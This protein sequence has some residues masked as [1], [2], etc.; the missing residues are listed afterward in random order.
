M[1][2]TKAANNQ[3]KQ[4]KLGPHVGKWSDDSDVDP[5]TQFYSRKVVITES[6]KQEKDSKSRKREKERETTKVS[7]N[8]VEEKVENGEQSE[9][10]KQVQ[11]MQT[12][13]QLSI[14]ERTQ[15][16]YRAQFSSR[17]TLMPDDQPS[18]NENSNNIVESQRVMSSFLFTENKRKE[19]KYMQQDEKPN[20]EEEDI[21]NKAN[22]FGLKVTS[23]N[24]SY[25]KKQSVSYITSI[26]TRRN[27]DI[28]VPGGNFLKGNMYFKCSM[29]ELK[30]QEKM[31]AEQKLQ[32]EELGNELNEEYD[33][34]MDEAGDDAFERMKNQT[35][36]YFLE[37]NPTIKCR[38]CLE[39]GHIAKDCTNKTKRPNCIL[40]GKDTHDSFSC[41]EKTCFKCNKIGHLASQCTEKNI[42]KC[43]KCGII[44]HKE[45][46]CLKI[47]KGDYSESQ[48]QL[49]RCIQCGKKG[50]IKCLKERKSW[51]IAIDT[52]VKNN[53]NEFIEKQQKFQ[54]DT[55]NERDRS[56]RFS[57]DYADELN[58]EQMWL[59]EST[60][61]VVPEQLKKN[62]R[63]APKEQPYGIPR[64]HDPKDVYCCYCADKH[65]E[66]DC[67]RRMYSQGN[68]RYQQYEKIRSRLNHQAIEERDLGYGG[69]RYG[70]NYDNSN[71][72]NRNGNGNSSNN[73]HMR[74][75]TDPRRNNAN[76][77]QTY[78]IDSEDSYS[79]QQSKTKSHKNKKHR[80][81]EDSSESQEDKKYRKFN[82]KPQQ[83]DSYD[84][85]SSD[86]SEKVLTSFS[87]L[88]QKKKSRQQSKDIEQYEDYDEEY[89]NEYIDLDE[90]DDN[91]S[92]NK[93]NKKGGNK[94]YN[95]NT[96]GN[97]YSRKN[98]SYDSNYQSYHRDSYNNNYQGNQQRSRSRNYQGGERY[99]SYK[100][101]KYGR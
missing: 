14:A 45:A 50:H 77:I 34:N 61:I 11:I 101:G 42:I 22:K 51:K 83:V 53:L 29:E 97:N 69:S 20:N 43:N 6:T 67:P 58:E 25:S 32:N 30:E 74:L 33:V 89:E 73:Y 99:N 82:K 13:T 63:D 88:L 87:E 28:L 64:G 81:Y 1:S 17:N 76:Q 92:K 3:S 96:N 95:S 36:R 68:S 19:V 21:Q 62:G 10:T 86:D 94:N 7:N 12:S 41:T 37:N 15:M 9:S 54:K 18:S 39:Y 49:L 31:K 78:E 38:N 59:N 100:G 71:N 40:C 75:A 93:K 66:G 46:R 60:N 84:S 55:K 48:M 5:Y 8:K 23:S 90:E 56:I 52:S 2:S 16:L 24:E 72:Y 85:Q 27:P 35:A 70:S 98:Y 65:S 91:Y 80:K 57:F 26:N 44:G 79:D 4:G 47:W